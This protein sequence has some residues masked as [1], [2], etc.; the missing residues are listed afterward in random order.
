MKVKG[1]VN[2]IVPVLKRAGRKIAKNS[3]DI[4]LGAG[5]ISTV[6]GT[7]TACKATLK[8]KTIVDEA[9]TTEAE[10][11]NS[12]NKPCADGTTYTEQDKENDKDILKKQTIVKV[13]KAYIIPALLVAGGITMTI[14]GHGILKDRYLTMVYGYNNL[15]AVYN[16]VK[17]KND[18][19]EVIEPDLFDIED[20]I[21]IFDEY[22]S[23]FAENNV[24]NASYL[25]GVLQMA[26]HKLQ[27]SCDPVFLNDIFE[28]LGLPKTKMG[29]RLGWAKENG[30]EYI[31]FGKD[32]DIF[33]RD[34][35]KHL[36]DDVSPVG[37]MLQFNVGGIVDMYL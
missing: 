16:T 17:S 26:N 8:V 20:T 25:K 36:Y 32:C 3:P 23:S 13:I 29:C 18:E 24:V 10:I 34:C 37:V 2:A 15:M 31:S 12:V 5:I 1:L 22:C 14:F 27:N 35:A 28:M 19:K 6:A 33:I 21:V 11:D 4:L 30:D 7:I 9:K